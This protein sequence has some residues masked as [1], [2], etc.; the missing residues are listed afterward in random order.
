MLA[1]SAGCEQLV[2]ALRGVCAVSVSQSPVLG[3]KV[4]Y[5]A[6]GLRAEGANKAVAAGVGRAGWARNS[7]AAVRRVKGE[8]SKKDG[9]LFQVETSSV[10]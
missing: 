6:L 4:S 10:D 7:L 8:P 2:H 5:L 9:N 3:C 1:A